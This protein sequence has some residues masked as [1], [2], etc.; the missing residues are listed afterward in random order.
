MITSALLVGLLMGFLNQ[1]QIA[2]HI[3][4]R[5]VDN[6]GTGAEDPVGHEPVVTDVPQL[7]A[8]PHNQVPVVNPAD[9]LVVPPPAKFVLLGDSPREVCVM[10]VVLDAVNGNRPA[11]SWVS[12]RWNSPVS[13]LLPDN[14]LG[15]FFGIVDAAARSLT[16]RRVDFY[17]QVNGHS[18]LALR[19]SSQ[20]PYQGPGSGSPR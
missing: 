17:S 19:D 4:K 20:N 11:I 8:G 16:L 3:T 2:S 5:V 6:F 12:V 10:G 18:V 9:W 14:A 7:P 15:A 1:T 13:V